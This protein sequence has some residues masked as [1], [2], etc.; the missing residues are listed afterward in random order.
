M[1]EVAEKVC[2]FDMTRKRIKNFEKKENQIEPTFLIY[3]LSNHT[4][5]LFSPIMT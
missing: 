1:S 5:S 4:T 3:H 2:E